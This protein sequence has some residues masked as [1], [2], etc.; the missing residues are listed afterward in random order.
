MRT[1]LLL[2]VMVFSS[3]LPAR[4]ATPAEAKNWFE[5]KDAR[6][7]AAIEAL[8]RAQPKSAEAR[9]LQTRLLLRQNKSEAALEAAEQAVAL[10]PNNA[11]AQFW[12][13]NAYGE[14]IGQ[15]GKLSQMT[16]APK[17]RGA[18]ERAVQFDPS[19]LAAREHLISYYLQAP[20]IVGGG[21]DKAR[22]QAAEI[23]RRDA[24]QGHL[25]RARIAQ[26]EKKPAET[27][28]AFQAAY[29]IKPD[30]MSVR[31]A[32][33]YGYQELRQWDAAFAHFQAW[34]KQDPNAAMAWYQFGKTSALSGQRSAD[35][36]AALKRYLTLPT[37][38]Q[39]DMPKPHNVYFRLGQ[40]Q[41]QAGDKTAARDS[42]Q[43]A[44]KGD[45]KNA[46]IKAALDKL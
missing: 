16:M 32:V 18:Y 33:G 14:R 45:P 10:A 7:P 6:A 24:F 8:V 3:L 35:G 2:W 38:N 9:V 25:A 39:P 41:A 37:S 11:Q 17:L 19:L 46:E 34:T 44:L 15:V 22:V 12:L 13:G 40:I 4:A 28:K 1:S 26:Y 36:I 21:I 31:A 5:A 23:G 27:L 20:A 30:D 42:L 43:R 29:A